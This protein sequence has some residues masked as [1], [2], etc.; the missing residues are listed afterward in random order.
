VD[1]LAHVQE[2]DERALVA[3]LGQVLAESGNATGVV[4]FQVM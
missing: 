2:D 4:A 3:D 1:I